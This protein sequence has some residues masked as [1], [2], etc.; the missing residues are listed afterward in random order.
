LS[1]AA[2]AFVAK[3]NPTGTALVYSTY[4]GGSAEERGFGIAVDAAGQTHV[5]GWTKSTDFP[6]TS[7]V[8][9]PAIGYADPAISNAFVAKLTSS[10]DGLVYA[11][12]LGGA[13]CLTATVRSCLGMFGPD[14]GIDAGTSIAV[15]AAGYAY[16]GGYA[17]STQ[18]PLV[19]S[20]QPMGAGSDVMRMPLL[21]KV[22][23]SGDRLVY[24]T[25]LGTR[26]QDTTVNQVAIDGLGGAI[27]VG[28]SALGPFPLTAGATGGSGGGVLFKLSH[29][30]HPTTVRSS[31]GHVGRGQQVTLMAD[32]LTPTPGG[33]VT[34]NDGASTLGSAAATGG[35]A[36]LSVTLA[37]GVHRITAT[38]SA[39]G[40]V[41]PPH[42]QIVAGQ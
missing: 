2:D 22:T 29:G 20:L 1:G 6:R 14:D 24:A 15:D 23:P 9:Q 30:K 41:S 33:V 42:F 19:D 34:F 12:Y 18:F 32:V 27:A 39:D 4:L 10:G 31:S 40:L 16:V 7:G 13:W 5:T 35:V 3:V 25:V 37:P 11:S 26:V 28:A 36:S 21:A 38:N 8:F 17:T